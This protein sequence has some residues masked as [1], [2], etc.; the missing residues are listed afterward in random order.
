MHKHTVGEIINA[1]NRRFKLGWVAGQNCAGRDISREFKWGSHP[2]VVGHLNLIHSNQI[3]V[4]GAI[5]MDYLNNLGEQE[6]KDSVQK[7][8]SSNS[9]AVILCEGLKVPDTFV[10][11]ANRYEVAL[12]TCEN[13][14]NELVAE[15]RYVLTSMLADKQILH[16][17]FMEVISLGLLIT[18]D[19]SIG[20]SEL[21]LELISRGHRLIADDA[22]EFAR[23]TPDI[24]SGHAPPVLQDLLEVRGLGILN[25]REM[26]GDGA[27]KHS[28]Y[29]RLIINLVKPNDNEPLDRISTTS[30]MREVLGVQVVE[31]TLPVAPGRNLAVMVEAAALDYLLKSRGYDAS[32]EL[33]ERQKKLLQT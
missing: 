1:L 29:L 31:I 33:I 19:S 7:L 32:Q 5:E 28:K 12:L 10:P 6:Y 24:V 25:I 22:P 15:L 30:S 26:Y 3:Q 18:G 27:I 17:V 11:L 23:I 2:K 13:P 20:K 16:G 4:I 8:F 9:F 14:S 21:A